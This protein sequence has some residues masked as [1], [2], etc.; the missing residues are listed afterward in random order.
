MELLE[1]AV[2]PWTKR[3]ERISG[4]GEAAGDGDAWPQR[5][6]AWPR[7]ASR[8]PTMFTRCSIRRHSH[9]GEAYQ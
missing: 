5:T 4:Q 2:L 3:H 1:R 8:D 9:E 6:G 7:T